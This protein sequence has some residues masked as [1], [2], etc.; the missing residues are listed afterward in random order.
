MDKFLL[1]TSSG[2]STDTSRPIVPAV[3]THE[4]SSSN[5]SDQLDRSKTEDVTS[6]KKRRIVRRY[7]EKFL[8]YGFVCTIVSGEP[9]PQCVV[10]STVLSNAALIPAKLQRHL[11]TLHSELIGKPIEYF[12]RKRDG[13][14]KQKSCMNQATK[15]NQKALRASYLLAVRIAKSKKPHNIGESLILP[16]AIEICREMCGDAV[17]DKLKV[18]PVSNDTVHRRITSASQDV[19]EQLVSRILESKQFA[20]QLDE[21]TDVAGQAQLIAYARYMSKDSM[22]EDFLFC[23][24]LPTTT[25]GED[26]FAIVNDFIVSNGI[27][28]TFCYGVCTDGAAAMTGKNAGVWAR[29]RAVAPEAKF[30]HCLLHRESLASKSMSPEVKT[31]FDQVIR[32]VNFVKTRPLSSRIFRQLCAE[33]GE[34]HENLLL[35]SEVRWLSRGKVLNRLL[36]LREPLRIFLASKNCDLTAHLEDVNWVATMAYLADIFEHLNSLNASMQ[37]PHTNLISLSDKV[38]GFMAKLEIWQRRITAGTIDNFPQVK[39]FLQLPETVEVNR[40]GL[41]ALIL[42]HLQSLSQQFQFY[43]GDLDVRMYSWVCDP[44]AVNVDDLDLPVAEIDQLIELSHNTASKAKHRS[45]SLVEFWIQMKSEYPELY[46]KAIRILLPFATSYLCETGFSALTA[47]KTKHRARL[48]VEDDL[49]LC[50][51]RLSPRF[52]ELCSEVQAQGSH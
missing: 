1:T 18:I 25:T 34:E 31:V 7:D 29:I 21:S 48:S 12:Q 51:S 20:I 49:R 6:K 26:I 32:I 15:I 9:R 13:L 16:A 30:T 40:D 11:Q 39:A 8:T 35:H 43:F 44:F 46:D 27:D 2:T 24:A 33:M 28:W 36:E 22:E 4:N 41:V 10:C 37:G 19:K 38:S 17:A 52:D 47:I 14:S 42:N 5:E 3:E 23:Q 45:V 50:I